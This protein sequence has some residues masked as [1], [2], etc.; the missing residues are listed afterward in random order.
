MP[1]TDVLVRTAKSQEKDYKMNDGRGLYLLVSKAGGKHWRMK[2]RVHGKEKKL[3]L[4]S[5]P[6]VSLAKARRNCDE[7][8]ISLADGF[9]PALEKRK[10]KATAC[11][12]V[13][14]TFQL[15]AREH[16]DVKMTGDGK[17]CQQFEPLPLCCYSEEKQN[18]QV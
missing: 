10:A 7:A 6:D 1:L 15:I 13:Q 8:R 12:N 11:F 17:W 14:N 5:Y 4:G 3:A 2:Y 9:D 16:I 18:Q